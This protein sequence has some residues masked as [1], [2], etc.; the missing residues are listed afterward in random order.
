VWAAGTG[1]QLGDVGTYWRLPRTLKTMVIVGIQ[2]FGDTWEWQ[3][4]DWKHYRAKRMF[5]PDGN[6]EDGTH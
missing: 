6:D 1:A 4:E 2:G 5:K 3:A